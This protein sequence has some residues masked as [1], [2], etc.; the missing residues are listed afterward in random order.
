MRRLVTPKYNPARTFTWEGT[1][2]LGGAYL[3][4]YPM[5]S[6]GG[7]QLMGRTLPIWSTHGAAP[8]FTPAKP[9][10]LDIFDQIRF[11]EVTEAELEAQRARFA[12]GAHALEI[13]RE[14]FDFGAH[15]AFCAGAAAET[16]AWRARQ[17]AASAAC[18]AE[19]AE[20]LAKLEASGYTAGGGGGGGAGGMA[21]GGD[22]ATGADLSKYEGAAFEKSAAPFA[23]SVWE[24]SVATGDTVTAGQQLLCLE[25]MKMETPV[26][27][28]KGGTVVA[29][30]AAAGAMV[31]RG[32]VLV[33]VEVAA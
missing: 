21:G 25:A 16:D 29:V 12:A 14:E 18:A 20:I 23:A 24:V 10:L 32:E 31:G 13:T 28:A 26:V 15:A 8:P 17:A 27:A 11:H 3:C 19:D 2:G 9:W 4:I 33:V 5:N 6:P 1:V 30:P 7:Y 22:A